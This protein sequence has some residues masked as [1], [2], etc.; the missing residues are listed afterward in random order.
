ME[1]RVEYAYLGNRRHQLRDGLDAGHVYR[2]VQGGY[3]VALLYLL[4]H[5]VGDEDAGVEFFS[6]VNHAV[7]YGID[8]V[9]RF[10]AAVLF[11]GK[12]V[13]YVLYGRVVLGHGALENHLLAAGQGEFQE[14]V[15][16]TDFLGTA[17][18]QYGFG[19]DV[20]QFV[21]NRRTAAI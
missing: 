6:A 16:Q 10:D 2:V 8:F 20:E 21:F 17:L 1:S 11:A 18:S 3:V 9:E 5:F 14:R 15:F 7:T 12:Y 4:N 19:I 13:E